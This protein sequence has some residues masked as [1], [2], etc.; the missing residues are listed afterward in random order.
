ML[1]AFRLPGFETWVLWARARRLQNLGA[2]V[3][4]LGCG[5]YTTRTWCNRHAFQVAANLKAKNEIGA[6]L[7]HSLKVLAFS[8]R[9]D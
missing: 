1:A 5:G 4:H 7:E 8:A 3:T 2:A 9:L 6:V